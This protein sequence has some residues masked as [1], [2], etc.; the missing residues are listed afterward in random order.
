M[1]TFL[2]HSW[3]ELWR[4][5][6]PRVRLCWLADT[7]ELAV[8]WATALALAE[9]LHGEGGTLPGA[10]ITQICE[11][12]E[13]P[14]L[15]RWLGILRALTEAQPKNPLLVGGVFRLLGTEIERRF[16]S[17][18][19]DVNAA[20]S[21]LVLR[22]ELA[23]GGG[24]SRKSA[25]LLLDYHLPGL[26][27][28]LLAV[29]DITRD[30]DIIG[31]EHGRARRLTGLKPG[32]C[33]VPELLCGK[34]YGPW[35]LGEGGVLP[36]LPLAGFGPVRRTAVA[37]LPGSDSAEPAAQV[38][39]RGERQRLSYTPLGCDAAHSEVLD[40]EA[41][42][43]FRQMFRL[44]ERPTKHPAGTSDGFA[45]DDF[46]REAR[47]EAEELVG[48]RDELQAA[49]HWLDR[50]R[51][52][53]A[54][55]ALLGWVFGGP[56]TGKSKLMAR[57]AADSSNSS[58]ALRGVFYHRFRAGDGRNSR[59]AFLRL[60]QL[61]L[62]NWEPLRASTAEPA[63][64][65]CEDRALE[66][67]VL[68]RLRAV[69]GLQPP[70]PK[71]SPPAFRII[72][73]G[74]DE[75]AAID[76]EFCALLLRL[77]LPGT[78][79]LVAGR[80]EHGL[81]EAFTPPK[82]E[83]VFPC[84]LP[85]MSAADI[86]AM[87]LEGLGN[88]RYALLKRDDPES[89]EAR[90]VFVDRVV[91][92][93]Q[94]LPLY[95]HLL[96][97]DLCSGQLTVREE[98]KLPEGLIA[99]YD[100]LIQ[101]IGLST[102]QRDLTMMVCLLARVQEPLAADALALL[103]AH[104]PDEAGTY[105]KRIEDALRIG[106]SLL[107]QAPTRDAVHGWALYHQSFRDYVGGTSEILP[108][109]ALADA[110]QEA[111]GKLCRMADE[112]KSLPKGGL[113]NHLFR[114]GTKYA[115]WWQDEP[116]VQTAHGRLTD[117]AYL[118]A[119][120]W[121]LPAL[122]CSDLAGE[123]ALVGSRLPDG[124]ARDRFRIWEAFFRERT[125]LLRRGDARWP[126][127]RILLQLALEHADDSPVSNAAEQWLSANHGAQPLLRT[128][129]RPKLTLPSPCLWTSRLISAEGGE[130]A[131]MCSASISS[132]G[133]VVA[134]GYTDG[135]L[136][137]WDPSTGDCSRVVHQAH[138]KSAINVIVTSV[139]G[140]LVLSGGADGYA[141]LW[142]PRTDTA[143]AV[144][145]HGCPVTGVAVSQDGAKGVTAGDDGGLCWWDL[146]S[147]NKE[148]CQLIQKVAVRA[149]AATPDCN[150]VVTGD[151]TGA[152]RLWKQGL[153]EQICSPAAH[154][155]WVL[156][157]AITP[158]ASVVASVGADGRLYMWEVSAGRHMTVAPA[159]GVEFKSVAISADGG[160][161]I[162][163]GSDGKVRLHGEP[164]YK[165]FAEHAGH[166]GNVLSVLVYEDGRRFLSVGEDSL[167]R[168]WLRVN[169][170]PENLEAPA[171][172][173]AVCSSQG[174]AVAGN[175]RGV[176]CC[177][178][179]LDGRES[180][181]GWRLPSAI[182]VLA[183]GAGSASIIAGCENGSVFQLLGG[184]P[185]SVREMGQHRAAVRSVAVSSNGRFAVTGGDDHAVWFWDLDKGI[186][187][188]VATRHKGSVSSLILTPDA[189]VVVSAS[190]RSLIAW[191]TVRHQFRG[192]LEA[193]HEYVK[194]LAMSPLGTAVASAS[195]DGTVCVW[196]MRSSKPTARLT[197][198]G[199]AVNSIAW[200]PAGK[201]LAA[202]GD[203]GTV[204]LWDT[205]DWRS[206]AVFGG[207]V[208][209]VLAVAFFGDGSRIASGGN[210]G[211]IRLHSAEADANQVVHFLQT[212]PVDRLV[213]EGD[214][215]VALT[216]L[217]GPEIL[218]AVVAHRSELAH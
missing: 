125:H 116:G 90:N 68:K 1:P 195:M 131:E 109:P 197:D 134:T 217:G 55:S 33:S 141:R 152:V 202:G 15:G 205:A 44:D 96:I 9:V 77:T 85:P 142:G 132:L 35:L 20:Q 65:T 80:A 124:P 2:A 89:D 133:L 64:E 11:H 122:E 179:L 104:A 135:R 173:L 166:V 201:L 211:T 107:R 74:L 127:N 119:R 160:T 66:E 26:Q 92:L 59:G 150:C 50:R 29:A 175:D 69:A 174:L 5:D 177:W 32:L 60:L 36:L 192:S 54:G 13:R 210:D 203:D 81:G 176:V 40:E 34:P 189:T 208:G 10:V 140:R 156:G 6:H 218:R 43:E 167:V 113:S 120:T 126:A 30:V 137:L 171:S 25:G 168:C 178:S 190:M 28:L 130:D 39:T 31:L 51:P 108:A 128:V 63:H 41:I 204:R 103:L 164:E 147:G 38:Y 145:F 214:S 42:R 62:W 216:R 98:A 4:E 37:G 207:H 105:S 52:R 157:L 144:M 159:P 97:E 136:C 153:H 139:D 185:D 18:S 172:A 91:A 87:L 196:D 78:E 215:V 76:P 129:R 154:D 67:D 12:I 186:A 112:W 191:D 27:E 121:A 47:I 212:G 83:A 71:A 99:Y 199:M 82:C 14:T 94:G 182:R 143:T 88:A 17:E 21:L 187:S 58:P 183:A 180:P 151:E 46:L 102:V 118:Q 111:E 70:N 72:L 106:R 161:V 61:A 194:A 57:L 155:D 162:T 49:K 169:G 56:G 123:Y 149:L 170:T 206:V 101:R 165:V 115:L 16:R 7:A 163:G 158:D 24:T 79:W 45:W 75:V 110:V 73:D 8:R 48:R 200:C 23:H 19:T 117:F 100:A 93:S 188:G 209:A 84:G 53:D 86:R 22:N 181:S 198:H 95:V 138:G 184:T 148:A 3:S 213:I 193:H 146:K 114:W